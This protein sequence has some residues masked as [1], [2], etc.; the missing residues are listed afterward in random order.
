M[1]GIKWF[2]KYMKGDKSGAEK[3]MAAVQSLAAAVDYE[4]LRAMANEI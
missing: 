2:C 1:G 3:G 4:L